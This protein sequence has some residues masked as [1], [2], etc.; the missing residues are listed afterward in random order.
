MAMN[1]L[2]SVMAE[3][4]IVVPQGPQQ[5]GKLLAILA[6]PE[7]TTVAAVARAALNAMSQ[8]LSALELQIGVL[9][10]DIRVRARTDATARR[11]VTIPRPRGHDQSSIHGS[12]QGQRSR[13]ASKGRTHDCK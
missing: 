4:G 5:I 11:L 2:R 10:K 6:D 9:D 8:M 12:H 13:A 7:D 3:F 1:S